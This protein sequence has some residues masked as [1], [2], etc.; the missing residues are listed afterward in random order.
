MDVSHRNLESNSNFTPGPSMLGAQSLP[1][2]GIGCVHGFMCWAKIKLLWAPAPSCYLL[3]YPAVH[4]LRV[5]LFGKEHLPS[6]H[7]TRL[8]VPGLSERCAQSQVPAP[9][10]WSSPKE[11]GITN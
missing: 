5:L 10:G 6:K 9:I 1:L 7:A 8:P 3:S 2:Y 4:I 11:R